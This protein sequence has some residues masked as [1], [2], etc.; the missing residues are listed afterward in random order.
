MVSARDWG[1]GTALEGVHLRLPGH[2]ENGPTWKIYSYAHMKEKSRPAA[3]RKGLGHL[4]FSV[5]SVDAA[6][7]RILA[8]GGHDLGEVTEAEVFEVGTLG[9]IHMTDPEGNILELQCWP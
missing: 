2:G 5:K 1:E 6:R 4:A 9:F 8:Q 3:N 7:T